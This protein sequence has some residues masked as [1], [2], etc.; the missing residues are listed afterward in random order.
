MLHFCQ[1]HVL[2][3]HFRILLLSF[4]NIYA[5]ICRKKYIEKMKNLRNFLNKIFVTKIC[6]I[7]LSN[8]KRGEFRAKP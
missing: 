3:E 5:I 6:D 1:L 8:I 7:I 2:M 4:K